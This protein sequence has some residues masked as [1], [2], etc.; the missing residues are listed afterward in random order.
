MTSLLILGAVL[1]LIALGVGGFGKS[2]GK[3]IGD[4]WSGRPR[5]PLVVAE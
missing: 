3:T 5:G 1:V 4:A 2:W